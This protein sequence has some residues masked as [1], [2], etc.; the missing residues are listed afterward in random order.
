MEELI[1]EIR[2]NGGQAIP[3]VAGFNWAYDLRPVAKHPINATNIAYVS[4]PYPMKVGPPW[5]EKWT[6]DW[7]F[8][9]PAE[10]GG[11]E[12]IIGDE[13]YGEAIT[14]YCAER[15]I[16]YTVWCFDAQWT[17]P[18]LKDWN[19]TPSRHGEFFRSAM[20]KPISETQA[21]P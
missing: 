18:L 17:P 20:Q 9:A 10:P 7:G 11:Y 3:L 4:H 19:Y 12:P 5:E 14:D 13:K 15:G 1:V 8:V 2:A 21:K 16:S 6:R